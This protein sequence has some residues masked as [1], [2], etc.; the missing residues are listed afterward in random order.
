MGHNT[1]KAAPEI[2][3]QILKIRLS[4]LGGYPPLDALMFILVF[5]FGSALNK[6]RLRKR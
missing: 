3:Y 5:I 1:F 6:D 2:N 4:K